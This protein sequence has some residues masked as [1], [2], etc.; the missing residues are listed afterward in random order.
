MVM[1]SENKCVN[2]VAG[3]SLLRCYLCDA[4]NC[5]LVS[6]ITEKPQRE[7]ELGIRAEDYLRKIYSCNECGIFF[8]LFSYDLDE[9]YKGT[10][11][12]VVYRN[13]ILDS[14]LEIREIPKE[15]SINKQRVERVIR[16]AREQGLKFSETNVLDVG[17]GLCVF[18]GEL[19]DYGFKCHCID[20]DPFSVKHGR[21]N[22]K[23]K[24][25]FCGTLNEFSSDILFDIISFNK[26]LE[27][28][29]NPVEILMKSK[30]LLN[31][32][33]F[34]YIELPDATSAMQAGTVQEREEFFIDHY[35]IFTTKSLE[36]LVSR[37][38]FGCV[39]IKAIRE[40]ADKCTLYAFLKREMIK[41]V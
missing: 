26:V 41:K 7:V 22:V 18:L 38:G 1:T 17:S 31:D 36:Y 40:P 13:R 30:T 21:K 15:Q 20:P 23:V 28:V 5:K 8:N 9:L 27:H 12:K 4:Y 32:K 16:F 14:Y 2:A 24:S 37:A 25:A 11:N 3:D 33:G 35:T 10:Y 29:K 6:T 34:V 39:E 19:K